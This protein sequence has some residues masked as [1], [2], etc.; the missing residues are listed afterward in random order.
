MVATGRQ[1]NIGTIN[2][3]KSSRQRCAV[4]FVVSRLM[5]DQLHRWRGQD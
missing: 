1:Y 3:V 4:L 2:A 5:R